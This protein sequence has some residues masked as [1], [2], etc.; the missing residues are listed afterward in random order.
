MK[1]NEEL[2]KFARL[3]SKSLSDDKELHQEIESELLDH[4][5][6]AFK[7]ERQQASEEE[8]LRTAFKRFGNP[9]EI[10]T[11]LAE[12]NALR[13]SRHARIRRVMK[14][15]IL[16]LLIVGVALCID[17]RGILATT[18][19]LKTA[20]SPKFNAER[21]QNACC[22][23]L[24]TREL[25][26]SEQL[27]FDFYYDS[28]RRLELA[29]KL[30]SA[31]SD[32]AMN[33]AILA[34]ELVH[35][36]KNS[37]RLKEVLENGRRIDNDNPLY[38]F[39]E[40]Y[41]L[42]S[43]ASDLSAPN[44]SAI[45]D[46]DEFE[47]A[48]EIYRRALRKGIVRTY[49]Y[50]LSSQIR[51]ML[52]IRRDL[53]GGMQLFDFESRERLPYLRVFNGISKRLPLF[54]ERLH[55]NGD[56]KKAIEL[57][58]TWRQ[59]IPQFLE[60]NHKCTIDLLACNK[61]AECF[62][63]SAKTLNATEEIAALQRVV[64]WK[65]EWIDSIKGSPDRLTIGGLMSHFVLPE[66]ETINSGWQ[67]ERKLEAATFDVA[68]LGLACVAILVIVVIFGAITIYKRMSGRHPFLFIM[69][70]E[71]YKRLFQYGILLPAV[72]YL[73]LS[74]FAGGRGGFSGMVWQLVSYAF[75]CLLWPLI[76]GIQCHRAI[77]QRMRDIG[78]MDVAIFKA[79]RH[80]NMLCLFVVLLCAVGGIM[81][82][83][84]SFRQQYYARQESLLFPWEESPTLNDKSIRKWQSRLLALL[85]QG[86]NATTR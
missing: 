3:C 53:L 36:D 85:K 12:G 21:Y 40:V 57:L 67:N 19:V 16:P 38:D 10:S 6:E 45:K 34:L 61:S 60:G 82:P 23:R 31:D 43:N 4:L 46:F 26:S 64:A 84:Q 52:V 77:T 76:F 27:L 81:R 24:K 41:V 28:E 8:A 72:A 51:N 56:D 54:C 47:K 49:G 50:E 25:T 63:K 18:L 48:A 86:N 14:W 83:V 69:S 30:F 22:P 73:L 65:R 13:L 1:T 9:E 59:F 78:A 44:G 55:E 5:E 68:A 42:M 32:N 11:Q 71:T 17:V 62:M 37:P 79:S 58:G 80:L 74:L 15:L 7:E 70:K 29:E 66:T 75:L 2:V 39:I 33:C 20:F 35:S